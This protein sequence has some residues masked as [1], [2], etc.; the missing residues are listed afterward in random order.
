[1]LGTAAIAAWNFI[2][3]K[4]ADSG[5]DFAAHGKD[6]GYAGTSNARK[7]SRANDKPAVSSGAPPVIDSSAAPGPVP[8]G[9]GPGG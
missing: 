1:V 3:S 7:T 4:S 6:H 8:E 9:M 5:K 2:S